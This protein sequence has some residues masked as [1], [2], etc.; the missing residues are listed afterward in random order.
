MGAAAQQLGVL[1]HRN[2]ASRGQSAKVAGKALEDAKRTDAVVQALAEGVQKIG[3]VVGLI[4]NIAGQTNL[5]AL[6]ANHF[7]FA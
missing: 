5:L 2:F 7:A 4:S 3:K 6:N 1:R